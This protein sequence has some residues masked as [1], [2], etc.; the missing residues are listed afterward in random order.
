[1][2]SHA[3]EFGDP[4][5]RFFLAAK[6][7]KVYQ[8]PGIQGAANKTFKYVLPHVSEALKTGTEVYSA[9]NASLLV[10]R[11]SFCSHSQYIHV[12]SLRS[13]KRDI[14]LYFI[15][16]MFEMLFFTIEGLLEV[17]V[18]GWYP[19]LVGLGDLCG[20]VAAPR[21]RLPGLRHD[22]LP[23]RPAHLSKS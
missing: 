11:P 3:E 12:Y 2:R 6:A 1:M 19:F 18:L 14:S 5:L 22:L 23:H 16:Y 7:T 8:D 21:L 20:A 4:S 13:S 17:Y 9:M 15:V 10:A